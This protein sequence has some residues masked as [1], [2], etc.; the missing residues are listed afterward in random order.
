[1]MIEERIIVK[2]NV[3][4]IRVIKFIFFKVKDF[5]NVMID[6]FLYLYIYIFLRSVTI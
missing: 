3:L 6:F 4:S 1:M 5:V 2:Q